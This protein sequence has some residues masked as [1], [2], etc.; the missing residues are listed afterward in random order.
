MLLAL[1][2]GNTNI[3]VGTIREAEVTLVGRALTSAGASA[4]ELAETLEG[5]LEPTGAS[6]EDVSEIALASVVPDVSVAVMLLAK[7]I[8]IDVLVADHRTVPLPIRV[9]QPSTV[10][11]DRLVNALAAARLFGTPAIVVDLGTATT[12]DVVSRGRRVHRRR[13]RPRAWRSASRRWRR[14]PL[15]CRACRWSCR[16][17]RS[18]A[19]RSAPCRVAR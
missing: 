14:E 10:G 2:V 4:D 6:L 1:D 11:D 15:S 9:D 5:I 12:F 18:R 16:R 17:T 19:T 8:D 3:T 7:R 13:D